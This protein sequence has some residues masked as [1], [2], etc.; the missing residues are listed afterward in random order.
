MKTI[1]LDASVLVACLFK[2]G[3]ARRVL[4][5]APG[6][7]FVA[8]PDVLEEAEEQVPRI[9]RR[10]GLAEAEIRAVLRVLSRRIQVVPMVVLRPL[11]IRARAIARKAGDEA[12]WEYVA[13]SLVAEAPIWS[14]DHDFRRMR[15]VRV[16][17]T[18]EVAAA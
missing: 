4:L 18:S 7:R 6:A 1:V 10:L 11:E 8:P 13:L 15:G 5:S 12:D 9:A 3:R 16:V 17:S 14:Y 2:D